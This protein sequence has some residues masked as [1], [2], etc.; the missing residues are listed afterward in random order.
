MADWPKTLLHPGRAKPT[1]S[2]TNPDP[3]AAAS[4]RKFGQEK[5]L[6]HSEFLHM[7]GGPAEDMPTGPYYH[8]KGGMVKKGSATTLAMAKGGKV[9]KTWSK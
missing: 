2:F 6:A 7:L 3:D 8:R 9:I 5:P 1:T 4:L